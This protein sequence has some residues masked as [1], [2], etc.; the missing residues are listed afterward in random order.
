M[1]SPS[2]LQRRLLL[3]LLR[4]AVLLAPSAAAAVC[5]A[6]DLAS[7]RIN[8]E[9]GEAESCARLA[10]LYRD[11]GRGVARDDRRAASLLRQA[12]H[13]GSARGCTD[14]D[15]MRAEGRG[16]G[17]DAGSTGAPYDHGW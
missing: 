8:C 2:N 13:G 3:A 16:V 5:P 15:R 14:L 4:V 7:C 6:G 1:Q 11:G 17:R 12:C 9:G 10:A